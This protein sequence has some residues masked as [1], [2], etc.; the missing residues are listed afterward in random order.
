[1]INVVIDAATH[2][3]ACQVNQLVR[4][5]VGATPCAL[6]HNNYTVTATNIFNPVTARFGAVLNKLIC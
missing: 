4:G 2:A 3:Q 1:M 5:V 6:M